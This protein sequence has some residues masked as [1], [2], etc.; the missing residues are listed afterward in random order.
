MIE[1]KGVKKSYGVGES[2]TQVL[3]GIDLLIE[4]GSFVVILGASGSGKST[5][6]NV[7]SGLEKPDCGQVLYDG[8]DI[9]A[10]SDKELTAFRKDTVGFVFQQYFLLPNM[11][12]DKNVRMG[13]DLALNKD[14]RNIIAAV[15]LEDKLKKYPSQLSGGEQQRVS[16]ARALAKKPKVLFLDEPT[17]ALDENTGRQVLDYLIGLQ[18]EYG[19]TMIMVTHNQN[20]AQTAD[21]VVAINSG[22]IQ[23]D[24]QNQNI[25]SAYE[26]GW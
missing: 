21:R 24:I 6:L 3:K 26:I 4:D 12:V 22:L 9:C 13:A 1:I 5:L 7:I 2:S 17:G 15:G 16:I 19:F 20:I 11:T 10:L 8:K 18:K 25:K 23:D 14:Y